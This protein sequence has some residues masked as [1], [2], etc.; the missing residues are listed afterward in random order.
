MELDTF[1]QI[2]LL[3]PEVNF[4]GSYMSVSYHRNGDS[5]KSQWTINVEEEFDCF[6]NALV[7]NWHIEKRG[8]SLHPSNRLMEIGKLKSGKSSFI[9]RFQEMSPIGQEVQNRWHGYPADIK[10]KNNDIPPDAVLRDWLDKKYI[11]NHQF[12]KIRRASL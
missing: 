6:K 8:W 12:S 5:E 9:I 1:Y 11:K 3:Y 4:N 2:S 7:N 10:A